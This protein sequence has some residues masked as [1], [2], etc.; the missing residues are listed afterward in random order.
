M[1]L[2]VVGAHQ[3]RPLRASYHSDAQ[4]AW[5]TMAQHAD[6]RPTFV[7]IHQPLPPAGSDGGTHRSLETEG[8]GRHNVWNFLCRY[9]ET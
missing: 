6:G 4:L 5:Q 2:V 1:T 3:V 8:P 9:G 7:F